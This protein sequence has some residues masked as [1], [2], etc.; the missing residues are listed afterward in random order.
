MG[1]LNG[2][3]SNAIYA[4]ALNSIVNE[5]LTIQSNWI[6]DHFNQPLYL[7]TV[8]EIKTHYETALNN[9]ERVFAISHSQGG[10]FMSDAFNQASFTDKQKHFSGFQIASP[11]PY[12]MNSH[13]GY[14]THDK[15][16]LINFVRGTV[17]ALPANINAPLYLDNLYSG[18]AR[19]NFIEFF[20]NHGIET[21]YLYDST[22][23]SQVISKL[24][25]AA[26]LLESNCPKAVINYTKNNLV[27]NFDSTDPEDPSATG[28]TYSWNFGDGQ[29][30]NTTSKTLS[31]TY[32]QAGTYNISLTVTDANGA[33]SSASV[34]VELISSE[35]SFFLHVNPQGTYYFVDTVGGY[36][37]DGVF[38]QD[39]KVDP[40]T[41]DLTSLYNDPN[42]NLR[43]G[44][45]LQLQSVGA[46]LPGPGWFESETNLVAVFRDINGNF[47]YPGDEGEFYSVP[48]PAT[49]PR[50]IPTDIPQDFWIPQDHAENLQ[51]PQ[52]ATNIAFSVP[53][54]YF[55]DN[56]DPNGDYGV[57]IKITIVRSSLGPL[58]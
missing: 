11:L 49:Y 9:G 51:V 26:Q 47:L 43:S 23:K 22:I 31:H 57:V 48:T 4:V 1:F 6:R 37:P 24:I 58:N 15:D 5:Y 28:L 27:V 19:D 55:T 41:L 25:E 38:L 40:T 21:T 35:I 36:A 12:E 7:Q 33:S 16:R 46:S 45:F 54:S 32:A 34:P 50:G 14:A 29:T 39:R 56:S 17:G 8:G 42:I 2:G 52:G 20:I 30:A 13:F 44:D 18:T 10:L 3:L 53:D